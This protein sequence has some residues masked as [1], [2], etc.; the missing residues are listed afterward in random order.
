MK[1]DG[2]KSFLAGIPGGISTLL[3]FTGG[4]II[5][6]VISKVLAGS[7]IMK[8]N[9]ADIIGY[10]AF[11]LMVAVC[12]Y[13]IVKEN[14]AN[15]IH[16]LIISNLLVI[17]SA[18]VHLDYLNFSMNDSV[19]PTWFPFLIGW[20]IFIVVSV[21]AAEKGWKEENKKFS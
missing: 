15:I 4:L 1:T 13:I 11:N 18:I 20:M 21:V 16:V 9:T 6:I 17:L 7:G 5:A 8:E 3:A 10:I 12:C 14:P 19:M 2:K